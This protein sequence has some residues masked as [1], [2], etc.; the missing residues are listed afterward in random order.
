MT[1]AMNAILVALTER[2]GM[3]VLLLSFVVSGLYELKET[4]IHQ[5]FSGLN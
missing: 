5:F 1:M 3:L 4:Y 2:V